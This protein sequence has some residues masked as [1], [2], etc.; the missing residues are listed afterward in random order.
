MIEIIGFLA[1]S[2]FMN[3]CNK[4][5]QNNA[6]VI[7]AVKNQR[8]NED[9]ATTVTLYGS[10]TEGSSLTFSATSS[11]SYVVPSVSG[12]TLTLT[13]STNWSGTATITIKAN[14]GTVDSDPKTF[15]LIVSAVGAPI[16]VIEKP[17]D[18][19]TGVPSREVEIGMNA[20][21]TL[22]LLTSYAL[23]QDPDSNSAKPFNGYRYG[24]VTYYAE[25]TAPQITIS[26]GLLGFTDRVI[27]L[28]PEMYWTGTSTITFWVN[29]GRMESTKQTFT[30]TVA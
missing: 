11:T 7:G 22:Q 25:S 26:D 12:N 17:I 4:K 28:V 21:F 6:P 20:P 30:V 19:V 8:T 5:K 13:P 14:D 2:F 9:T 18:G 24:G 29:D 3:G 15:F 10:D 27:R 1:I 16:V 23:Y